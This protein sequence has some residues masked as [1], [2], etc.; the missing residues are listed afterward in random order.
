[1][2][3]L[4]DALDHF[5]AAYHARPDLVTEQADWSPTIVLVAA[6]SG[7]TLALRVQH[8]RIAE[9]RPSAAAADLVITADHAT[10]C[11][12]LEL[13]RGPNEP[14][15]FGELTVRGREADFLRLDYLTGV[16]CPA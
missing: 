9:V 15:L 14:Y 10:L 16:L 5:A 11:D 7:E 1:M 8:G 2:N 4:A 3:R 12:I 13:R 6:D